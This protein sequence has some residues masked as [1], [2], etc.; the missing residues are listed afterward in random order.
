MTSQPYLPLT[1]ED[2]RP[3]KLLRLPALEVR[4]GDGST[5]YSF[6]V[7]GKKLPFFATISR[8]HR[9]DD[10]EIQGYQ[11][12][13][14]LSHINAIRRYI[15]SDSPMIPNALVIAFDKRVEFEPLPGVPFTDY[16]R[17]GTIIIPI[18][19]DEADE[20]KPGWI[21]DGQQRSA[22]IRDARVDSFPICVTAFIAESDEAQRSQFILVNS[23]KPLPKGLIYELLPGTVGTL[24]PQFQVREFPS[25]LLYRLNFMIDSPLY[26]LIQTP[27]NPDGK[28][29]DNSILK[30]L[31]NSL[32]DGALYFFRNPQTG[33][34]NEAAMLVVLKDFWR[35]VSSVFP[36]AW[37]KQPRQS[38]LMHGAGIASLG[39]LMDTIFD[40]YIRVRVPAERDFEKDLTPLKAVCRWTTGLWDFG[41]HSQRKWNELQNTTKDIQVLSEYLINEYKT[42]VWSTPLNDG[43]ASTAGAPG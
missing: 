37:D 32:S 33:E 22:A 3:G 43:E 5:L 7:D 23:A 25:R 2:S 42:R 16:T 18:S 34:Y 4:Q 8:I 9:D 6:A 1:V 39:F 38:R 40:R 30:M 35:A 28:I 36:E 19:E 17:H 20:D 12:P 15:E 41:P 14:V 24:P 26:R 11:R 31:E 13:A 21:V 29:K 27:T 10:S